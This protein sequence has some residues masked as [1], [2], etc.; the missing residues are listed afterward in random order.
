MQALGD[1]HIE[2]P[3]GLRT[4]ALEDPVIPAPEVGCTMVPEDPHMMDPEAQCT[5]V[6]AVQLMTAL[7]GLV[8]TAQ[9]GL[10]MMGLAGRAMPVLAEPGEIVLLFVGETSNAK[11]CSW[12]GGG[13]S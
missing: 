10:H 8:T 1:R 3:G 5:M 9:A 2:E 11:G 4:T 6:P 13:V 12:S 7:A